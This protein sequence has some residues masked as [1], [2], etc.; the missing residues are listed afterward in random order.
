MTRAAIFFLLLCICS[1]SVNA[2]RILTKSIPQK[3]GRI[4]HIDAK[5]SFDVSLKTVKSSIINV[6]AIAEGEY[7]NDVILNLWEE[8]SDVFIGIDFHP[9]YKNRNDKLGAHK[10]LSVSLD[11]SIP[12]SSLV[13]LDG[14]SANFALTGNY[15]SLKVDLREGRCQLDEV[16]GDVQ[17]TTETGD[18]ELTTTGGAVEA[19]SE[20]G[21]LIKAEIPLGQAAY[22]LRSNSGNIRIKKAN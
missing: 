16:Y 21:E 11:I 20:Y 15:E 17:V 12:E 10:V 7:E 22:S 5:N 3:H 6:K 18:I 1:S 8:G 2:Q 13:F 14:D 4:F 9:D 19:K